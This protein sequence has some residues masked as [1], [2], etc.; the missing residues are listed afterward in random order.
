MKLALALIGCLALPVAADAA[1]PKVPLG[2][3]CA[4]AGVL[5][6]DKSPDPDGAATDPEYVGYMN[7]CI[8]AVQAYTRAHC[9]EAKHTIW[10]QIE[11]VSL[12]GVPGVPDKKAI[13]AACR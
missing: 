4:I 8:L 5:H 9:P 13:A 10:E 12:V 3:M 11:A 2:M 1:P 6:F 7:R